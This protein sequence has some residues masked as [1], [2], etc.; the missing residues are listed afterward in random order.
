M[1]Q[2]LAALLIALP[3]SA[4]AILIDDFS[5]PD[6][7]DTFQLIVDST[8]VG[9]PATFSYSGAGIIGGTRFIS[10]EWLADEVN[11]S[12]DGAYVSYGESVFSWTQGVGVRSELILR[13]DAD[14]AGLG[15]I[16]FSG[17][18][19]LLVDMISVDEVE[20]FNVAINV[21]DTGAGAA[22][23]TGNSALTKGP[24]TVSVIQG[25]F[26]GAIDWTSI[27]S[28]E[29]VATAKNGAVGAPLGEGID[30]SLGKIYTDVPEPGSLALMSLGLFGLAA[31]GRKRK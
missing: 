17:G 15:G 3:F 22:T 25:S 9:S 19:A 21:T 1:K 29:F 5:E 30:V 2:I 27:D 10:L 11:P 26:V 31:A 14:G 12:D 24:E 23:S 18:T 8:D 28:L 7:E 4:S 13:Y 6:P 16:D 20:S